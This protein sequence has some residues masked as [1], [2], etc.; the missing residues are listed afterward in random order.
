M[1]PRAEDILH[2]PWFPY[3]VYAFFC[4]IAALFTIPL[5]GWTYWDFGDGNYMYI[6]R[7]VRE[8]LVLYRDVLA[9]QPPLHTLSGVVAQSIGSMVGVHELVAIRAFT[10]LVRLLGGLMILNLGLRYFRCPLQALAAAAVYLA[11]PIGFWW[12]LCYQSENLEIVF[13]V[14]ALFCLL[15]WEARGALLAGV[16]SALATHCNMTG[17]P[18]FMA[19]LLFLLFRRIHLAPWY[20]GS[21]LVVY[22]G[23]A[24]AANVWTDGYFITNV[25]LNQVGTFPRT[26]ILASTPAPPNS[27]WEYV[28]D[29]VPREAMN[30]IE[31]EGPIIAAAGVGAAIALLKAPR[32]GEHRDEWHRTEFL[33]WN[34]IAG[35]LSICFTAKGGTVNYIFVL[36]EPLVALF[37]GS[38][39]VFLF[40]TFLPKTRE[41]WRSLSLWDTRVFLKIAMPILVFALAWAPAIRNIGYTLRHQQSELPADQVHLIRGMIQ[42]YANPGDVIL[43]PPFYAFLTDTVVAGELAENYI[44]QIK[45][46]NER[47]DEATYGIPTDEAVEK[48]N[49]IAA[50]LEN[51]EVAIVLLDM[52]QTGRVDVIQQA[53]ASHYK[54]AEN[55]PLRTRNTTLRVYIPNDRPITHW[56]LTE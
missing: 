36:G 9:P 40:R 35:L 42:E 45:W 51:R 44:W 2:R 24:L 11:L 52:A 22:M 53:L 25:L 10:L 28:V 37:A 12:S 47:F 4:V 5:W 56:R 19:N 33:V 20:A 34:F 41:E 16:F 55:Q 31:I 3:V 14:A 48:F 21:F 8:G 50:M 6:A 17:L 15:K 1:T 30:V 7:R 27:F 38:A 26:D 18:F 23:G 46:M 13:L 39:F 43:A 54:L 32:G 49:E 29:K